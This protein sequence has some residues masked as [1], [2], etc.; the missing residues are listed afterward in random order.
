MKKITQKTKY[1][2]MCLSLS[3]IT[4]L[5]IF[6]MKPDKIVIAD[7]GKEHLQEIKNTDFLKKSLILD[8]LDN[9]LDYIIPDSYYEEYEAYLEEQEYLANLPIY[10]KIIIDNQLV[11]NW[12]EN[13]K[14]YNY[15]YMSY[16][17]I[18]DKTSA[19]YSLVNNEE[20]YT[21]EE[22][23]L[24][25]VNNRFCI[26]IGEGYG[27]KVGDYIDVVLSNGNIL[28]CIMAEEKANK[29]TDKTNKYHLS[30]GSVIEMLVDF[31]YFSSTSQYPDNL[32]GI[33]EELRKV[34]YIQ[35]N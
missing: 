24:R 15:T 32:K 9:S 18:T 27:Y 29:D 20:T 16:K 6:F 12:E 25:M 14:S 35:I 31:N 30:D 26:A 33:I 1:N 5:N 19:Q 13:C 21:D 28:E 22:T 2:I 8:H 7:S 34:D 11:P 17:A 23:G 3:I 4:G 10:E